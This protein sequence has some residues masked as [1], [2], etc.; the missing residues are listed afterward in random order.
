MSG[1]RSFN[2]YPR[3]RKADITHLLFADDLLMFCQADANSVSS[4]M[5]TFD[6]FSKASGLEANKS[7]SNVYLA[8]VDGQTKEC[9]M[10]L[11]HMEEGD[12]PFRYLG[13]S[14][15]S[16]KLNTKDCRP[17]VNK[18]I[19]RVKFWSSRLL[20]YAGRIQLVRAQIFCLLTKFIK[21]VEDVSRSFVWTRQ[22]GLSGKAVIV[23]SQMVLHYAKG[24]LNLR[25]TY[26]WNK[27][28]LL[29]HLWNLA[30]KKD[31]LWVKWVHS[32]YMKSLKVHNVRVSIHAS[33]SL[34]KIIKQRDMVDLLGGW[35]TYY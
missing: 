2:F 26:K 6:R 31:N 28:A 18:I 4:M 24:G 25:H 14:L 22:E 27:A 19:G 10:S 13:V 32:Y 23:W 33:W 21:M 30:R 17:M 34:K 11:L 9:I 3:C 29:K 1:T 7:K 20:S 35:E 15:H 12:F 5:S 16:K 8:G